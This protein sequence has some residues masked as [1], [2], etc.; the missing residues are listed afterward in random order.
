MS[1]A[2]T[3]A[4]FAEAM[5]ATWPPHATHRQGPWLIREGAGGGKRVSAASVEGDWHE[6]DLAEAEEAML[7]LGSSAGRRSGN[8]RL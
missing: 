6:A 5:E 8:S 7:A 4:E 2:L 1:P 3:P